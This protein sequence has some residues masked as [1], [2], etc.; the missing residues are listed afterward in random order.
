VSR[1]YH[2]GE[3]PVSAVADVSLDVERGEFVALVGPSGCGK[4]TLLHLCGAMELPTSGQVTLDGLRLDQLGE[5]GLTK[6]RRE[7]LG[8]VFQFFNLLPTLTLLEN[9]AL[10]LM[11]AGRGREEAFGRA[12]PWAVRL[13]LGHRL[14]HRPS[15]L[16]GGEMQR[17]AIARAV[18]HGPVLVIADEPTGN[19]DSTTGQRI[20]EALVELNR[21][22]G[23]TLL[24]ATHAADVAAAAHRVVHMRDGR[25]ERV[26]SRVA[27]PVVAGVAP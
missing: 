14:S 13:G 7:R 22:H 26:E 24:L 2:A 8:F 11:L 3:A 20:L 10:P 16:S 12:E 19:L 6:V 17:A 27:P 5:E 9:I 21:E 25:I 1:T 18:V 4:S 15:Q 23:L